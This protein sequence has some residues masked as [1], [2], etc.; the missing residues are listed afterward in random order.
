MRVDDHV[1]VKSAGVVIASGKP[2]A[3]I[4]NIV[5]CIASNAARPR[6]RLRWLE[7]LDTVE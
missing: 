6:A 1:M 7:L 3:I 4:P 2:D 5:E